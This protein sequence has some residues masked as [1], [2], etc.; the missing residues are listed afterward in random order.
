MGYNLK[1]K[2]KDVERKLKYKNIKQKDE[3]KD[4]FTENK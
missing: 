1:Y 4:E 2:I 3:E